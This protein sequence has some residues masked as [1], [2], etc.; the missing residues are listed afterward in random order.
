MA[1]NYQK[2]TREDI[3]LEAERDKRAEERKRK[4][5]QYYQDYMR[6]LDSVERKEG[7]SWRAYLIRENKKRKDLEA[8]KKI[9]D[10][11]NKKKEEEE[12][13]EKAQIAASK[14]RIALEKT[15]RNISKDMTKLLDSRKGS[16]LDNMGIIKKATQAEAKIAREK[17]ISQ[18]RQNNLSEEE[19]KKYTDRIS[20]LNATGDIQRDILNDFEADTLDN[21]ETEEIRA[22]VLEKAGMTESQFKESNLKTQQLINSQIEKMKKG[23]DILNKD[24]FK[25]MYDTVGE[26]D[27]VLK[28]IIKKIKTFSGIAKESGLRLQAVRLGA[29]AVGAS[30][31]KDVFQSAKDVRQELGLSVVDSAKLDFR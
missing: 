29:L 17:T 21:L 24:G 7:M 8:Q 16:L 15:S 13:I 4:D 30:L 1:D 25:E 20:L 22:K 5:D 10:E 11:I 14:K 19:Q 3:R 18:L 6:F 9:N 31:A 23:I 27:D 12:S 26:I 28:P 2:R